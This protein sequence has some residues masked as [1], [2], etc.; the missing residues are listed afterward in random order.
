MVSTKKTDNSLLLDSLMLA[1][2]D[3]VYIIDSASM[4]LIYANESAINHN[5]DLVKMQSLSLE[6][7]FGIS[8]QSLLNHIGLTKKKFT[9]LR[10]K[11]SQYPDLYLISL[12]SD[13]PQLLILIKSVAAN[14]DQID[15]QNILPQKLSNG[16]YLFNTALNYIPCLVF[17]F[18]LDSQG[19][20]DFLY[21]SEGCKSLLGLSAEQL[22]LRPYDFYELINDID[23][24]KFKN[25]LHLSATNLNP[26]DWEGII[27]IE[28]WDD[29]KWIN[30]RATPRVLANGNVHWEGIMINITQSKIMALDAQQSR[31]DLVELNAHMNKVKDEER[32]RIAQEIHDDLGGNLTAIK[33][34]LASMINR[35]SASQG[36]LLAQALSL[37]AIVDQT[38]AKVQ[39][40]SADLRPSILDLGIVAALQWQS[41]EFVRLLNIDCQFSCNQ[42]EVP[43]TPDQAITLFRICQESMS[44]IAKHANASNVNVDLR[45]SDKEIILVITD[46]GVGLEPSDLF[47]PNVFGLRGMHERAVALNGSFKI[48]RI[49]APSRRGT[50]SEVRL[51]L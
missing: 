15:S 5:S 41:R 28:G 20:I 11:N 2:S 17:F 30:V 16:E 36:E 34:V 10:H 38:F 13:P 18:Q 8:P 40:I 51:P 37:E 50:S 44:N 14:A 7:L 48:T 4:R 24:I 47:K 39:Q 42:G 1:M 35:F 33:I 23:C 29:F 45:V 49:E 6:L 32:T 43:S 19:D 12:E 22:M 21:L 46:D 25:L 26:F 9:R 3:Q 27:W 31:E